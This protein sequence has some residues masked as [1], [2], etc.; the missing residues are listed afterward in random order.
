MNNIAASSLSEWPAKH[1]L[2]SYGFPSWSSVHGITRR[3][4]DACH[5]HVETTTWEEE[6]RWL[7][8]PTSACY[9][10]S[11]L[12]AIL[13]PSMPT[14]TY[15]QLHGSTLCLAPPDD[16]P[17]RHFMSCTSW[18]Y[19]SPV[20][21]VLGWAMLQYSVA[22]CQISMISVW[23]S[24]FSAQENSPSTPLRSSD[25][26]PLVRGSALILMDLAMTLLTGLHMLTL[27]VLLP[28]L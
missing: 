9:Y 11:Y 13:V 17:H 26:L 2:V 8:T 12:L 24:P 16:M 20:F 1:S 23:V 19:A 4:D 28:R 15:L 5:S 18:W 7:I 3:S 6:A 10:S 21:L 14:L 25:D 22:M 27:V